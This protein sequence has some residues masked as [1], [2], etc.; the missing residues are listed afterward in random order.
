MLFKSRA[1]ISACTRVSRNF[2]K[3]TI[4]IGILFLI[5]PGCHNNNEFTPKENRF[6]G[7]YKLG[8]TLFFKSSENDRDT[9]T[10]I[11]ID[12]SLRTDLGFFGNQVQ[13]DKN[14]FLRQLPIDTTHGSTEAHIKKHKLDYK[15]FL[16][17]HKRPKENTLNYCV[18]FK[19][20]ESCSD[21][22][23]LLTDTITIMG[24]QIKN[25]YSLKNNNITS[26]S[27]GSTI[28]SIYWTIDDG[29]V[30]YKQFNGTEWLCINFR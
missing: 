30:A 9:F 27:S 17:I 24:K 16:S 18:R 3:L 7:A 26:D 15:Q 21:K 2:M 28:S 19:E 8:D 23:G 14:I 1:Y 22:F 13:N 5:L 25:C 4:L 29:L 11:S 20:F 6:F 12:S 10:I